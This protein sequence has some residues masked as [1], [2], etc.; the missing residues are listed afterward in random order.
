MHNDTLEWTVIPIAMAADQNIVRTKEE[1][2]KTDL[3]LLFEIRRIHEALTITV[4]PIVIGALRTISKKA[5][6]WCDIIDSTQL[7]PYS[8]LRMCCGKKLLRH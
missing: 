3:D 2:V 1:K 6:A 7:S 5:R 4:I 8:E